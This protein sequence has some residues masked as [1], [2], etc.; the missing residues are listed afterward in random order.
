M[1]PFVSALRNLLRG[2]GAMR[3]IWGSDD[4]DGGLYRRSD[5]GEMVSPSGF[6]PETY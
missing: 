5:A 2:L 4:R 3:R 1:M 6:E